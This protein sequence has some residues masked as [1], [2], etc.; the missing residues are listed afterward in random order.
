MESKYAS[1]RRDAATSKNLRGDG[2]N[3]VGII[4]PSGLNRFKWSAPPPLLRYLWSCK[5]WPTK[6]LS[7]VTLMKKNVFFST[8]LNYFPC[9]QIYHSVWRIKTRWATLGH[10]SSTRWSNCIDWNFSVIHQW[11]LCRNAWTSS[12]R[13]ALSLRIKCSHILGQVRIVICWANLQLPTY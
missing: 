4:Y 2:S 3:V 1:L 12:S 7:L 8:Q 11:R 5:Y 9:F 13:L 10:F 6:S